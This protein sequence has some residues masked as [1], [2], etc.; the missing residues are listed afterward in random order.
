ML[1][2]KSSASKFLSR[3][4]LYFTLG[5]I[6]GTSY[7]YYYYRK[8]TN[9]KLQH[10]REQLSTTHFTP[11]KIKS[12][13]AV[14][15]SHYFLKLTPVFQQKNNVWDQTRGKIWS[16]QIK[17]P[18]IMIVRDYTPLPL[19]LHKNET[20]TTDADDDEQDFLLSDISYSSVSDDILLYIK[21]YND[22][23]VSRWLSNLPLNHKIEI[24]GPII[25]YS[26]PQDKDLVLFTAGTGIVIAFQAMLALKQN[27]NSLTI[28][29]SCQNLEQLGPL[30]DKLLQSY[31]KGKLTFF[32]SDM[33]NTIIN[34]A[35]FIPKPAL[36]SMGLIC[37]P[38]GYIKTLA[39]FNIR[40]QI[41]Y[42]SRGY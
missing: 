1:W 29:H 25:D 6:T 11:Y 2:N 15:S 39:G 38:E 14:D 21:K 26:L 3:K 20:N 23:E 12:R 33:G 28:F 22:G 27:G 13:Y 40:K 36:N 37:G 41:Q 30:K 31:P 42:Q 4:K 8:I 24:R 34:Q 5:F 19:V 10:E 32:Q 7:S 17:Q 16:I 9:L 35:K 18:E